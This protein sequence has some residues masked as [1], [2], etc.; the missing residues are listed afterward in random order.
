MKMMKTSIALIVCGVCLVSPNLVATGN[1]AE[2]K[3]VM[4]TLEK[5]AD[6]LVHGDVA[7]LTKILHDDLTYNHSSGLTQSKAQ[8]LADLAARKAQYD[9]MIFSNSTVHIYGSVAVVKTTADINVG[10]KD[11]LVNHH[12]NNLFVLV[13]GPQGWQMMARHTTNIKE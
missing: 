2:E 12:V 3:E 7:G 10:P 4:A 11:K 6:A 8:V 5:Y 9:S 1:P 13:K